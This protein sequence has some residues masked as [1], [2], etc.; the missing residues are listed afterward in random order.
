MQKTC[1]VAEIMLTAV[2]KRSFAEIP[3]TMS[4]MVKPVIE[5]SR[6]RQ[7]LTD[8]SLIKLLL[9]RSTSSKILFFTAASDLSFIN[10]IVSS[11]HLNLY[12]KLT[13]KSKLS[14]VVRSQSTLQRQQSL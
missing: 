1:S 9:L 13:L 5:N 14:S 12:S 7:N 10:H 8:D 2:M 3:I 11:V 4:Y 6:T